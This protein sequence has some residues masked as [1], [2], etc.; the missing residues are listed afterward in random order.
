MKMLFARAVGVLSVGFAAAALII[1]ATSPWVWIDSAPC[2]LS[3][4]PA[5]RFHPAYL[6]PGGALAGGVFALIALFAPRFHFVLSI[7]T[8]ACGLIGLAGFFVIDAVAG[9]DVEG[10][11]FALVGMVVQVIFPFMM[12]GLAPPFS[13]TL[14][15]DNYADR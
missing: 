11:R 12:L 7:L 4:L 14:K 6:V 1:L 15:G 10:A 13:Q 5:D 9:P 3:C 8:M 2:T